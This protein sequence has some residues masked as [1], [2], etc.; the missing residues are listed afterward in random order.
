MI[1]SRGAVTLQPGSHAFRLLRARGRSR[2][3]DERVS[4]LSL[5][6][7]RDVPP[8]FVVSRLLILLVVPIAGGLVRAFNLIRPLP[9]QY[10]SGFDARWF[11]WDTVWYLRIATTGYGATHPP[12]TTY[13]FFPLY[14]LLV[15]L[16]LRVWPTTPLE[17]GLMVANLCALA[18]FAL[19]YRLVGLDL[20]R[21][22]AVRTLWVLAFSPTSL[23]LSAAYS[24]GLFL[25]CLVLCLYLARRGY[26][27]WAGVAGALGLA[28]HATG[29][30]V[31]APL[32][33]L[34]YQQFAS[35]AR[36]WSGRS[37]W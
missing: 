12:D 23:Y 16:L 5:S 10:P 37:G 36:P 35:V 14:P 28:T 34:F 21:A 20:G 13:A 19:L 2:A 8:A 31:F 22:R 9:M 6:G 18:A 29:I 32:L 33:V 7:L 1:G 27:L 4:L 30:V 24:E 26:W 11:Q 17:A 3:Y 25:L 15:N